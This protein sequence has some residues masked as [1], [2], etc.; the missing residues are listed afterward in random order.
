MIGA[1]TREV[2]QL[3]IK[4][5]QSERMAALDK[6]VNASC[7]LGP[8]MD[9]TIA[10]SSRSRKSQAIDTPSRGKFHTGAAGADTGKS[11]KKN[12]ARN[13][14]YANEQS[15]LDARLSY[16]QLVY[17]MLKDIEMHCEDVICLSQNA[18]CLSPEQFTVICSSLELDKMTDGAS[19]EIMAK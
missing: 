2:S 15:W 14:V 11:I 18:L 1:N 13:G 16:R 5:Y 8:K 6:L 19:N 9:Q 10:G 17:Q 7:S 12:M 3:V 4:A